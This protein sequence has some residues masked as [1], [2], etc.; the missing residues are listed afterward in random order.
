MK[1]CPWSPRRPSTRLAGNPEA[2]KKAEAVAG[3]RMED[4]ARHHPVQFVARPCFIWRRAGRGRRRVAGRCAG[5]WSAATASAG[6]AQPRSVAVR[7]ERRRAPEELR[8]VIA[9]RPLLLRR[10]GRT[11][12]PRTAPGNLPMTCRG[13]H[14]AT[15]ASRRRAEPVELRG[16]VGGID[17]ARKLTRGGSRRSRGLSRARSVSFRRP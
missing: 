1:R 11:P 9:A 12:P 4:G 7:L 13:T 15:A 14:W 17:G 3:S 8:H 6:N 10:V 2:L 5:L 16:R